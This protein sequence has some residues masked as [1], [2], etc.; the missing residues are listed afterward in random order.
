MCDR[1]KPNVPNAGRQKIELKMCGWKNKKYR[2][3]GWPGRG[4]KLSANFA[5]SGRF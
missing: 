4:Q 2:R 5:K 1:A 3:V